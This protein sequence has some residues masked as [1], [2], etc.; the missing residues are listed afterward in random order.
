MATSNTRLT[1]AEVNAIAA[2]HDQVADDITAQRNAL[3]A[4][5]SHLVGAN[6]GQLITTLGNV[7][8]NWDGT[9]SDIV[10]QLRAMAQDMRTAANQLQSE[11]STNA[12]SV[13]KAGALGGAAP[14]SASAFGGFLG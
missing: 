8:Q 10:T 5:V 7:H 1:P 14:A 4:N 9:T 2:Q 13:A 6:S 12:S 11:D 3:T